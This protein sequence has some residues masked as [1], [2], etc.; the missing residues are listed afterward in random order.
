[1][2]GLGEKAIEEIVAHRPFVDAEDL[3]FRK[4]VSYRKLNKKVID[5][6][7]RSQALNGI[8]DE[9]FSGLKH[10]WSAVAVKRPKTKKALLKNIE[11]FKP[12]GDFSNVEKIEYLVHLTGV[13]PFELV[14]KP[15]L[16]SSLEANCVPPLS[17]FDEVLGASWFVLR[18]ITKRNTKK[19]REYWILECIDPSGSEEVKCWGINPNKDRLDINGVYLIRPDYDPQW[20]FSVKGARNIKKIS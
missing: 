6:L 10:F 14:L 12:E 5:V 17:L 19:G 1:M 20:G 13:Y 16:L 7:V 3:L 8:V 11:E 15:Q 4:D 2:K 18:G 9:R